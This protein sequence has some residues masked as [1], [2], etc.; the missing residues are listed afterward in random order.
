MN[1]ASETIVIQ[2]RAC[3]FVESAFGQHYIKGGE[4]SALVLYGNGKWHGPDENCE[5]DWT[6]PTREA[7]EAFARTTA[8]RSQATPAELAMR[9]ELLKFTTI[10][11]IRIGFIDYVR[12]DECERIILRALAAYAPVTTASDEC[13][14]QMDCVNDDECQALGYC[15]KARPAAQPAGEPADYTTPPLKEVGRGKVFVGEAQPAGDELPSGPPP[16]I[17]WMGEVRDLIAQKKFDAV[18]QCD[19]DGASFWRDVGEK[20]RVFCQSRLTPSEA[21]RVEVARLRA[22]NDEYRRWNDGEGVE[23]TATDHATTSGMFA[24]LKRRCE[25]AESQLTQQAAQLAAVER[26][27]GEHGT[28]QEANARH[29]LCIER[30]A[31]VER[32]R[33]EAKKAAHEWEVIAGNWRQRA[34]TAEPYGKRVVEA[35]QL[36]KA[37]ERRAE[38]AESDM[39]VSE[40]QLTAAESSRDTLSKRVEVLEGSERTL[41]EALEK[42][43]A[44]KTNVALGSGY[45]S[46][47]QVV[48]LAKASLPPASQ[49]AADG[50]GK[51]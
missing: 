15:Q 44:T 40:Q 20:F 5:E 12:R 31:A 37:M 39:A 24:K 18:G 45:A 50:E 22:E 14:R 43:A 34:L 27:R 36:Y 30:L 33:D 2:G 6:W 26:E 19:Y 25:A 29:A 3:V 42:I 4:L 51:S 1:E 13:K 47:H 49:L 8:A 21:E 46:L 23:S 28:A 41:R 35:Y 10:E 11:I 17:D 16:I 38:A 7:A 48:S 9:E 32:E